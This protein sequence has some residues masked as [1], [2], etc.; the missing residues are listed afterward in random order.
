MNTTRRLA[1][2]AAS[3]SY[4]DLPPSTVAMAKRL[5]LDGLACL[6]VGTRGGPGQSATATV[7]RLGGN[8]QASVFAGGFQTS[9]RDAAF[10]NGVPLYR[11]EEHTHELPSLIRISYSVFCLKKK[12]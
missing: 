5:L 11:P 7:R 1:D 3:L 10:A 6:V 9:V 4:R 2:F 12:K 8:P